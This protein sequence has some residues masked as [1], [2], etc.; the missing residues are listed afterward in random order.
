MGGKIEAMV[1][2]AS[3]QLGLVESGD[4]KAMAYTGSGYE[5]FLPGAVSFKDAGYDIPFTADYMTLAPAGLPDK[6]KEKLTTSARKVAESEEWAKWS[7]EQGNLPDDITGDDLTALLEQK[8]A[9]IKEAI[10]LAKK[11]N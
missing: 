9:D 11:R 10:E 5:E 4:L 8:R 7:K 2:T 1:A 6:V 3:G